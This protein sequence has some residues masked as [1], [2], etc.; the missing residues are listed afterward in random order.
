MLLSK[1]EEWLFV[2]EELENGFHRG[3]PT[4]SYR[5]FRI[6]KTLMGAVHSI[7]VALTR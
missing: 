3:E 6:V 4:S 7:L 2:D 1:G 5:D